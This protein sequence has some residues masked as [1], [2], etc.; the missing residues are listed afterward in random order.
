[1]EDSC[2]SGDR[3]MRLILLERTDAEV[4][5]KVRLPQ[6]YRNGNIQVQCEARCSLFGS[7][8]SGDV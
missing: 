5:V 3:H 7:W 1:M 2:E 8:K 4:R 6:D